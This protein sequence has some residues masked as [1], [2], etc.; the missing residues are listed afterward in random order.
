MKNTSPTAKRPTS[1][2]TFCITRSIEGW[3]I[4]TSDIMDTPRWRRGAPLSPKS[5]FSADPV[6]RRR[7]LKQIAYR[8]PMRPGIWFL[9]LYIF[10]MGFL[11]GRAGLAF[12]RMRASYELIIDLKVLEL[13]RARTNSSHGNR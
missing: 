4:G 13:E 12:C 5:L 6:V 3:R 7:A 9:Y 10:R 1:S 8:L 11:D 2:R